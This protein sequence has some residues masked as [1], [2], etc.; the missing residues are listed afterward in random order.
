MNYEIRGDSLPVVICYPEQGEKLITERGS[1]VWMSENM[2][3]ETS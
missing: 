1:M 2:K 3:M